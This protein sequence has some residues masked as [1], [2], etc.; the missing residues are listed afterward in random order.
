MIKWRIDKNN[1]IPLYL[2]LKDLIKFYISTGAIQDSQQLPGVNQLARELKI[3]FE[4]VRK[5]YKELEKEGLIFMGR[6]KGTY[7]TLHK[8]AA[9]SKQRYSPWE[10][11][12]QETV[13][14]LTRR[15]LQAGGRKRQ[16]R[17]LTSRC[18]VLARS[19]VLGTWG[20]LEG[21]Q[22]GG[23][24]SCGGRL[25]TASKRRNLRI[26]CVCPRLG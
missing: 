22:G 13:R 12:P 8:S 20:R 21:T 16:V 14:V 25:Q 9:S 7:A 23:P 6:G 15:M 10:K 3:N 4:T 5:A 26:L 17:R 24:N 2:Q 18:L 19:S 11:D 1:K